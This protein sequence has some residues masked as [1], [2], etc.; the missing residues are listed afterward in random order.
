MTSRTTPKKESASRGRA[1]RNR[2]VDNRPG[3]SRSRAGGR[4]IRFP[5]IKITGPSR[6]AFFLIWLGAAAALAGLVYW[7]KS[8][9]ATPRPQSEVTAKSRDSSPKKA[10]DHREIPKSGEAA[11]RQTAANHGARNNSGSPEKH[12]LEP[13]QP[14]TPGLAPAPESHETRTSDHFASRAPEPGRNAPRT[15]APPEHPS[16][17]LTPPVARVAIVI[18]DFGVNLEIARKFLE[19][20]LP[21]TFSVLPHQRFSKEIAQLAHEN[22]RQVV[23]H[24]PMEP[25]GYPKVNPGKGALLLSM[26]G[27]AVQRSLSTALDSSPHISGVNNHMGSRFTENALLMKT[28]LEEAKRRGLYFID[29]FTSPRSVAASVA[30]QLSVAF[31]RRDIFLDNNPSEAAIRA[32]LRQLIRRARVQGSALAIGHPHESTLRALGREAGEFEREKIA[33]VPAGELLPEP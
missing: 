18:D 7:G 4:S 9:K 14:I 24:L 13:R 33:V 16:P 28:V 31:L 1:P 22:H 15:S 17:V 32:Q 20:P 29:S 21:V 11:H 12:N 23:L 3:S 10:F 30:Q 5:F 27:E 25:Q 2:R 26:S 6:L 19:V 8:S